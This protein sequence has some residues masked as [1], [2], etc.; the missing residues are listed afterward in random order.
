[1]DRR[2]DGSPPPRRFGG[3]QERRIAPPGSFILH[4]S[5][6]L[7]GGARNILLMHSYG[8][9]RRDGEHTLFKEG[10]KNI[11]PQPLAL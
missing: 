1:M 9:H 5:M 11:L 2:G 10:V 4:I 7:G 6:V 8:V 3:K